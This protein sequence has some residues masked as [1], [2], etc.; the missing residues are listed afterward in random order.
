MEIAQCSQVPHEA[1]RDVD[2]FCNNNTPK[3]QLY[4]TAMND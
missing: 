2:S 3:A 4:S 1:A